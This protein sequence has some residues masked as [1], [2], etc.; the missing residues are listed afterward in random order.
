[1]CRSCTR[2]PTP[3]RLTAHCRG[4]VDA[5]LKEERKRIAV[6]RD[7]ELKRV[8]EN[9]RKAFAAAEAA[10]DEKLRK[11]NEVYADA[12]GRGPDDATARHARRHRR[13]TIGVWP[14]CELRSRPVLPKLD[15]K[16][17]VLKE[18]LATSYETAWREMADR[19]REGM[20]AAA[21]ELERSTARLTATARPGTKGLDR[22][23]VAAGR[24]AGRSL[25]D[26]SARACRPAARNR[27]PMLA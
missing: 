8:E 18:R 4:L 19:W 10:R 15:E 17:K 13:S 1:M 9:Y 24:S 7:D 2:W 21:A 25:R 23:L 11:I 20:K 5:A 6:R 27:R 12:D 22:T 3:M 26:D 14:S 16:Y